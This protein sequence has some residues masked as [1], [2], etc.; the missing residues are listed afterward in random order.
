MVGC[1]RK[2]HFHILLQHK[3]EALPSVERCFVNID[4]A[5][6]ACDKHD[7]M[8]PVTHKMH[9]SICS[10]E[11]SSSESLAALLGAAPRD[12]AD[13]DQAADGYGVRAGGCRAV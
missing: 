4:Y 3:V 1:S 7:I 6:R 10:P 8:T 13:A 12:H 11:S 9:S 2:I 5:H